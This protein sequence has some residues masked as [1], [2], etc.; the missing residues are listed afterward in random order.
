[1]K[2]VCELEFIDFSRHPDFD[3]ESDISMFIA[4]LASNPGQGNHGAVL[5]L[6]ILEDIP[7]GTLAF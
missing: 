7:A 2:L 5:V 3:F 4:R 6:A 1:M